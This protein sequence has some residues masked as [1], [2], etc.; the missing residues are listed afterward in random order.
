MIPKGARVFVATVPV[1]MRRGFDGLAALAREHAGKDVRDAVALF[2]FFN[3]GVDRIK[4]LW[5]QDNGYC[6]L[7]KRLERGRFRP[8]PPL[9]V[10]DTSVAI[11]MRELEL[12]FAGTTLTARQLHVRG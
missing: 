8:P 7:A 9:H 12:I 1:D 3:R 2:V 5:W 6:V 4:V 10:G 11:E